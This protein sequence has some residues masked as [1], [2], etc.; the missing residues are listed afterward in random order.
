MKRILVLIAFSFSLSYAAITIKG[1]VFSD[2][3]ENATT[4]LISYYPQ[5]TFADLGLS[6]TLQAGIMSCRNSETPTLNCLKNNG[7]VKADFLRLREQSHLIDWSLATNEL[8]INQRDF[9]FMTSLSGVLFGFVFL[10]FMI[11]TA[12]NISS[13]RH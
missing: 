1:V 6:T 4:Y 12:V 13:K 3:D 8:G 11:F 5:I 9:N 2:F 7:F 10:F